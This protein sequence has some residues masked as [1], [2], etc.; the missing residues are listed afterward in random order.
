MPSAHTIR[1][2]VQKL[3]AAPS[4]EDLLCQSLEVYINL[5]PVLDAYLLRY[6]PIGYLSEGVIS[7]NPA[8][9]VHIR[10]LRDDIR[11]LPIIYSAIREKKAKYCAGVEYLKQITSKYILAPSVNAMA[12]V[13]IVF[14]SSVI[15]YICSTQFPADSAI[16]EEMLFSLT[17]FGELLGK[18]IHDSNSTAEAPLLSKREL[19]VMKRIAWGE[20]TKEMAA[21][22][23]ISELTVKQYVKSAI[24]KFDAQNRPHAVAELF[25]KGTIS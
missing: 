5:F 24:K 13:P 19:E 3:T 6:S 9:F 4:H 12:V 2:H 18:L 25:R 11:S 16:D 10:E 21:S 1:E 14:G 22:M 8:G 7:L 17:L 20:S 15:G 23:E